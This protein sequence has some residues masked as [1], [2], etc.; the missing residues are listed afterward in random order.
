MLANVLQC[1]SVVLKLYFSEIYKKV[2]LDY[3]GFLVLLLPDH[4]HICHSYAQNQSQFE[5][6]IKEIVCYGESSFFQ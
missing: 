6:S 1:F 2:Q 3:L 4:V 5:Y